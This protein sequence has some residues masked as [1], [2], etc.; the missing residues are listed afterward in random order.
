MRLEGKTNKPEFLEREI[1]NE[2]NC[3]KEPIKRKIRITEMRILELRE[4][5]KSRDYLNL[6][7]EKI[8]EACAEKFD[9]SENLFKRE[10]KTVL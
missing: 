10:T 2:C 7:I 9:S 3:K 1:E 5:L 8:G 6:A 4:K